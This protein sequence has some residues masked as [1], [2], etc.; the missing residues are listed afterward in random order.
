MIKVYNTIED[1]RKV[2]ALSVI[3][4]S[5]RLR[6]QRVISGV[7]SWIYSSFRKAER[8]P[9]GAD[10]TQRWFYVTGTPGVINQSCARAREQ[11]DYLKDFDDALPR[12]YRE[13]PFQQLDEVLHS[14]G[15]THWL[16]YWS[17]TLVYAFQNASI[18]HLSD[19]IMTQK[20]LT[21]RLWRRSRVPVRSRN[22]AADSML[23]LFLTWFNA[24]FFVL[25]FPTGS[26]AYERTA[27][28]KLKHRWDVEKQQR[29]NINRPMYL[30]T[31]VDELNDR[32][33]LLIGELRYHPSEELAETL[34]R[35]VQGSVLQRQDT[36]EIKSPRPTD[37]RITSP[38]VTI[39]IK[40]SRSAIGD[41][42]RWSPWEL[43]CTNYLINLRSHYN[44]LRGC[45]TAK[46]KQ[47]TAN[48]MKKTFNSGCRP[49]IQ[50]G[51]SVVGS[52]D[53][54]LPYTLSDWWCTETGSLFAAILLDALKL[55]S[56]DI[57]RYLDPP[58]PISALHRSE[59]SE[60][61]SSEDFNNGLD[62]DSVEDG[63]LDVY[64]T[65]FLDD[66]LFGD[67]IRIILHNTMMQH[68]LPKAQ[69]YMFDAMVELE[70]KICWQCMMTTQAM[71]H[72]PYLLPLFNSGTPF[73]PP[74][75]EI[76]LNSAVPSPA[77]SLDGGRIPM[78]TNTI[79]KQSGVEGSPMRPAIVTESSPNNRCSLTS[80]ELPRSFAQEYTAS[81]L[82]ETEYIQLD[83]APNM[84]DIEFEDQ[85]GNKS[86]DLS[87]ASFSWGCHKAEGINIVRTDR[88]DFA[89][90]EL[91]YSA[92]PET[93]PD[94]EPCVI[95]AEISCPH[96]TDVT[97]RGLPEMVDIGIFPNLCKLLVP[98]PAY[99]ITYRSNSGTALLKWDGNLLSCSIEAP[100]TILPSHQNETGD[101]YKL[102]TYQ[103]QDEYNSHMME[104]SPMEA[105]NDHEQTSS[106]VRFNPYD[107][108][109]L[110]KIS[111]TLTDSTTPKRRTLPSPLYTRASS[112]HDTE[113]DG[114]LSTVNQ[115]DW[116]PGPPA[117]PVPKNGSVDLDIDG[118][119]YRR[120]SS[121]SQVIYSSEDPEGDQ[122]F[123]STPYNTIENSA[124]QD[125]PS[126][127]ITKMDID[128]RVGTLT[129]IHLSNSPSRSTFYSDPLPG[130]SEQPPEQKLPRSLS[131]DTSAVHT[132][133]PSEPTTLESDI[134]TGRH[135]L[136]I[137][138]SGKYK[139]ELPR[140]FLPL[141]PESLSPIV[142]AEIEPSV[143]VSPQYLD[144]G[145]EPDVVSPCHNVTTSGYPHPSSSVYTLVSVNDEH[146]RFD[147]YFQHSSDSYNTQCC[148]RPT[149]RVCDESATP[150]RQ[151]SRSRDA[152]PINSDLDIRSP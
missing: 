143:L 8:D 25:A 90:S 20:E 19:F 65:K 49:F 132:T 1:L 34:I 4:S 30:Y 10:L 46:D 54:T 75:K 79:M 108:I 141:Q 63:E 68:M 40:D 117:N 105:V 118:S 116:S 78:S 97:H 101:K 23:H 139:V 119:R 56:L 140:P 106:T 110:R 88:P 61:S 93:P 102:H 98:H 125:Q 53:E 55:H 58:G 96:K 9:L 83:S 103:S 127:P 138:T 16:L 37:L 69:E 99:K 142:T 73:R 134:D 29:K 135:L 17:L 32:M 13:D 91:H 71:K 22:N 59:E 36:V 152:S 18:P 14:A 120:S 122:L 124:T 60:G 70:R 86:S 126:P 82:T 149:R 85:A 128:A 62:N 130:A 131:V 21:R 145:D 137:Y 52:L 92:Y 64:P 47:I 129:L 7:V 35:D 151:G 41:V 123:S 57:P 112:S 45:V 51:Y 80:E 66:G 15:H 27:R 104:P 5:Y 84:L 115:R 77:A 114:G 87:R 111:P 26:S 146:D 50:R 109:L 43:T 100:T 11:L 81:G 133:I 67:E 94:E 150:I 136:N 33:A 48:R 147:G 2:K 44:T 148:K 24:L 144:G 28:D 72:F 89:S 42:A 12:G 113:R 74:T 39:R 31:R 95:G 3:C 38:Y 6:I 107:E 76:Q 121:S